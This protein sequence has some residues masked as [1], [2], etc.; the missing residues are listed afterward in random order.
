ML[1]AAAASE[2]AAARQSA[3]W[4]RPEL[5]R[6]VGVTGQMVRLWELGEPVSAK[7]R[8]ALRLALE[9]ARRAGAAAQLTASEAL[10]E[11]VRA[12]GALTRTDLVAWRR[13]FQLDPGR[14]EAVIGKSRLA[15]ELHEER[16]FTGP[17]RRPIRYL[18]TGPAT[19]A[20]PPGLPGAELRALLEA[21]GLTPG[22]LADRLGISA[23]AVRGWETGPA[24]VPA[25]RVSEIGRLLAE[26]RRETSPAEEAAREILAVVAR[27]PDI[28]R[29]ELFERHVGD[30]VRSRSGLTRA[31]EDGLVHEVLLELPR[32]SPY[33]GL[34]PGR[35]DAGE[36][37]P[38]WNA[39]DLRQERQARGLTQGELARAVGVSASTVCSW[40]TGK[41]SSKSRAAALSDA[42]SRA[43]ARPRTSDVDRSLRAV[44]SAVERHPGEW[45]APALL[46]R[47]RRKAAKA[48]L[49]LALAEGIVHEEHRLISDRRG[50][51][52]VRVRLYPGPAVSI[53]E[54]PAAPE[55]PEILAL[56][57]AANVSQ[58]EL[59]RRVGVTQS[60][61]ALW[62]KGTP[63]PIGRR[64]ALRAALDHLSGAAAADARGRRLP[65]RDRPTVTQLVAEHPGS[66][67]GELCAR[68]NR[69]R[70]PAL[71]GDI[72]AA[73]ASGHLGESRVGRRVEL[74]LAEHRS[75]V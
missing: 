19:A 16:R 18:V 5:G 30:R 34:R 51:S 58:G 11:L 43:T 52:T 20:A 6:R 32:R 53:G 25:A 64:E 65:R 33:W 17:R 29:T 42:L 40:E 39:R 61:V 3:G 28:G 56:R 50:R 1:S 9:E 36:E 67:R 21:A 10:L 46:G 22:E 26:H 55:G 60:A 31:L 47:L 73:I 27:H 15:G 69:M 24:K 13:R 54:W 74:L 62:E 72:A 8:Q 44:S 4:S 37:E 23:G 75:E 70:R 49:E 63:V 57:R 48:A 59:A 12:R 71:A 68:V 45:S 35:A 38:G 2:I 41:R 14:A 66:T 7:R